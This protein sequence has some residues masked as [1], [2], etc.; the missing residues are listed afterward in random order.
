MAAF[1][2]CIGDPESKRTY[3]AEIKDDQ[4]QPFIG[5]NVGENVKGDAFGFP[6]YEFK[7]TGGSDTAGFPMRRGILGMRKTIT[8]LGGVG[9]RKKLFNGNYQK[10]TVCGHKIN[11]NISQINLKVAKEG[12]KKLPEM[13]PVAP[14]EGAEEKK[15]A[16]A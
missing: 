11:Q 15:E 13:F 10:K 2:L 3:K 16:K 5:L 14:K 12:A 7:I 8:S 6:G 9:F 1:K 4:A